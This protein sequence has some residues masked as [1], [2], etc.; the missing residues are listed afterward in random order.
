MS[1]VLQGCVRLLCSVVTIRHT[2]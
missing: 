1:A 2:R